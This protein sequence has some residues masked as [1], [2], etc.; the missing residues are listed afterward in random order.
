MVNIMIKAGV[1][2]DT[3]LHQVTHEFRQLAHDAFHDCSVIFHAGDLV[4]HEL[5]DTFSD[6]IVY[7]VHGNMCDYTCRSTLPESLVINLKSHTI[8]L[9]HGARMG[10]D[11]E[12]QL[13]TRFPEADCIIYGHTHRPLCE[14]KGEILF[15]NPGSFMASSHGSK[16]SYAILEIRDSTIS[17]KLHT[18]SLR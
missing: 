16:A 12:D 15:I 2:S 10:F 17:A 4:S 8:A 6:Q 13:W 1:L 3:H 9:C 5:L 7:A 14:R 11:I 18:V